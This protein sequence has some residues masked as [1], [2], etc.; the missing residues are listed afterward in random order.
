MEVLLCEERSSL[1]ALFRGPVSL[2]EVGRARTSSTC[3]S[4]VEEEM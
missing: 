2:A 1:P 3:L 4:A